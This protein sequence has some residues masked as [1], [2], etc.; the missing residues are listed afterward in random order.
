MAV[1]QEA[2]VDRFPY[3]CISR[4]T[5]SLEWTVPKHKCS[6]DDP[7]PFELTSRDQSA[8]VSET[9]TQARVHWINR[10]LTQEVERNMPSTVGNTASQVDLFRSNDTQSRHTG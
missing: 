2:M 6:A 4:V 7:V 3:F 10:K 8:V 1:T 9:T 5:K